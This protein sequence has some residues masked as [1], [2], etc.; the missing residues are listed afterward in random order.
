MTILDGSDA[1]TAERLTDVATILAVGLMR[2][3]A[4]MSSGL[5]DQNGESPLHFMPDQS[6]HANPVSPEVDA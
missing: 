1:N 3:Q 4:R 6:G 2:L 5:S